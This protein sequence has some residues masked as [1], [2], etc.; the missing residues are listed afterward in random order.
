MS[1]TEKKMH[2]YSDYRA[3]IVTCMKI[4]ASEVRAEAQRYCVFSYLL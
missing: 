3:T 1:Q 4:I 2:S